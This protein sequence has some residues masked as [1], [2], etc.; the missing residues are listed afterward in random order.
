[1]KLQRLITALAT[2]LFFLIVASSAFLKENNNNSTELTS[3][4]DLESYVANE[5]N[6]HMDINVSDFSSEY[7]LCDANPLQ[8]D[9][10]YTKYGNCE[11]INSPHHKDAKCSALLSNIKDYYNEYAPE[12]I[13]AWKFY[14]KAC[15]EN[16]KSDILCQRMKTEILH[17]LEDFQKKISDLDYVCKCEIKKIKSICSEI[18]ILVNSSANLK[19]KIDNFINENNAVN[20]S[21]TK[22]LYNFEE[23][24][25]KIIYTPYTSIDICGHKNIQRNTEITNNK[26]IKESKDLQKSSGNKV[27]IFFDKKRCN[28]KEDILYLLVLIKI[29]VL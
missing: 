20:Y 2:F 19:T 18:A 7:V 15:Q 26:N 27:G 14:L 12:A 28:N 22:D 11:L 1:M 17:F 4:T 24:F 9:N 29:L 8:L 5:S 23:D 6:R 16:E 3:V 10:L 13:H 25:R 21:Q